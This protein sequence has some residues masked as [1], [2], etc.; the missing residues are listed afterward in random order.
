MAVEVSDRAISASFAFELDGAA[1]GATLV[2]TYHEK[3]D[4]GVHNSNVAH[5][6]LL[7]FPSSLGALADRETHRKRNDMTA[8]DAFLIAFLVCI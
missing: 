1:S 6:A 5:Y 7:A 4:E 2:R 3:A 8:R